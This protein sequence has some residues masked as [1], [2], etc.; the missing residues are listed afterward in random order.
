[1]P[2]YEVLDEERVLL[3]LEKE[4]CKEYEKQIH[5]AA[6]EEIGLRFR[7]GFLYLL[8]V[9]R[10]REFEELDEREL[11]VRDPYDQER[12]HAPEEEYGYEHPPYEEE[13]PEPIRH[14]GEHVGV[15]DGIVYARYYFEQAE[16]DYDY[17]YFKHGSENSLILFPIRLKF[18]GIITVCK[19]AG[20]L[21][22]GIYYQILK[23]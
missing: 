13:T 23:G 21:N 2:V 18:Q 17:Y 6:H 7:E 1:V 15:H 8:A 10:E 11:R 4:P 22:R 20:L 3:L 9:P 16:P 19:P 14:R 5:P 12:E